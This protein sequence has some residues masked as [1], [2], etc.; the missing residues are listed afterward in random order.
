MD[1]SV[2]KEALDSLEI[3]MLSPWFEKPSWRLTGSLPTSDAVACVLSEVEN[4]PESREV[5]LMA[6]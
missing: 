5:R 1:C 3:A 2:A 4:G 6:G